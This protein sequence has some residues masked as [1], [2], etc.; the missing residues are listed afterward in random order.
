MPTDDERRAVAARLRDIDAERLDR[1]YT[2]DGEGGEREDPGM[3][4]AGRCLMLGAIAEAVGM[5]FAPYCFDAAPLR[6]RLADLIDP[7]TGYS[8]ITPKSP[9]GTPKCDRDA[10]LA[11]ADEFDEK[12]DYIASCIESMEGDFDMHAVEAEA[13]QRECARRIREACGEVE[14]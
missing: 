7:A 14:R 11:L 2:M 4:K 12:A 6:D 10:L 3:A 13:E 8:E 1:V 9:V 5:H